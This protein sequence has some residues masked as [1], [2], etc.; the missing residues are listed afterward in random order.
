MIC[1]GTLMLGA[2]F[3]ACN[4]KAPSAS[5]MQTTFADTSASFCALVIEAGMD[6][7]LTLS[8]ESKE[9]LIIYCLLVQLPEASVISNTFQVPT[10]SISLCKCPAT[11]ESK[12]SLVLL[13]QLLKA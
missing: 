12:I 1:I 10:S 6:K 11:S 13:N 8:A 3:V 9:L 5:S 2:S 4:V 7:N